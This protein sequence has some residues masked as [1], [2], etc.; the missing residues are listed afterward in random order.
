VGLLAQFMVQTSPYSQTGISQID[1]TGMLLVLG[2]RYY[3][4]SGS[5]EL[6]LTEDPNTRGAP[7]FILN[8]T[9]K[10]RF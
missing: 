9:C 2:G 10:K 1:N 4:E 3:V 5:L 6:S 8:F 7:D